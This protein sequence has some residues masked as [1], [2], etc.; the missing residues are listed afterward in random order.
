MRL[1]PPPV[2]VIPPDIDVVWCGG[3]IASVEK[4]IGGVPQLVSSLD[5]ETFCK[6]FIRTL[7][8]KYRFRSN[9]VLNMPPHGCDSSDMTDEM[10]QEIGLA[11]FEVERQKYKSG[12][13]ESD[14]T[15]ISMG[16]DTT[17]MVAAH[18]AFS[19]INQHFP[20][21]VTGAQIGPSSGD[22]DAVNNFSLAARLATTDLAEV[23]VAFSPYLWRG[24]ATQKIRA[25]SKEPF[26]TPHHDALGELRGVNFQFLNEFS[27]P[28]RRET[29]HPDELLSAP[30]YFPQLEGDT[31][32]IWMTPKLADPRNLEFELYGRKV[33]LDAVV[34]VGYAAGNIPTQ[35]KKVLDK[36]SEKMAVIVVPRASTKGMPEAIYSTSPRIGQQ[37]IIY[38]EGL[39]PYIAELKFRKLMAWAIATGVPEKDRYNW[40][41]SRFV[42]PLSREIPLIREG[43]K[44]V[45]SAVV[46]NLL[47]TKDIFSEGLIKGGT[48]EDIITAHSSVMPNR[49]QLFLDEQR[50]SVVRIA[51][52]EGE[53]WVH[54]RM[55]LN[56]P[57]QIRK[58]KGV[59]PERVSQ[60][61]PDN[62][63]LSALWT[64]PERLRPR[65]IEAVSRICGITQ[66]MA[67]KVLK[68]WGANVQNLTAPEIDI[69]GQLQSRDNGLFF[70]S[71]PPVV[72]DPNDEPI[73]DA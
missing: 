33:P 4:V 29:M 38:A 53:S 44:Y 48:T 8:K 36:A 66:E 60:Y 12:H 1:V 70:I 26:D 37:G 69:V 24:S 42:L 62:K 73:M 20:I 3:T 16:T 9:R 32:T 14:G 63:T 25:V 45:S 10:I 50:R 49:R 2:K 47:N 41:R 30:E 71:V 11:A 57:V 51:A 61:F 65:P 56:I 52:Q 34:V 40:V 54:E 43:G 31:A 21:I 22:T 7:S 68:E 27:D 17:E 5:F 13:S 58:D 39:P 28:R 55:E 59:I 6:E 46:T 15:I 64:S 23:A 35:C 19:I 18:L 72:K 67:E